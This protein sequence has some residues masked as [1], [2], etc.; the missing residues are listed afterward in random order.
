MSGAERNVELYPWYVGLYSAF[1][2]MPVFFLYFSEYLTVAGVLQLEAIYYAGVVVM[3]VPSGWTSDRLGRRTTLIIGAS[4]LLAGY[5]TLFAAGWW[6]DGAFVGFAIG[7]LFLAF[8]IAFHSGTKTSLHYESL[9]SAGRVDEYDDRE[10]MIARINRASSAGAALIGGALTIWALS[11]AYL[12]SALVAIGLIGLAISFEPPAQTD[13]LD[14][15]G[16]PS[17][18]GYTDEGFFRQVRQSLG[19][20]DDPALRWL[21][22]F[23]VAMT[24]LLHI[25]Y[26]FYQPY[27]ELLSVQL[28]DDSKWAGLAAGAHM[29]IATGLGAWAAGYSIQIR[30]RYGT[31]ATL[32]ATVTGQ[33]VLI[34]FL[35]AYLHPAIAILVLARSLPS[36]LSKA[37][38]NAAVTPRIPQ[39]HRAT[40]L[41]VQSLAGRLAFSLSLLGLSFLAS[42]RP[43]LGAPPSWPA[44]SEL[45]MVS[46]AVGIA[47][48]LA[49][50]ATGPDSLDPPAKHSG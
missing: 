10:A 23:A 35:G 33:V 2:W 25:P 11:F 1:F 42:V 44:L 5:S 15:E 22:G 17:T 39:T 45:L 47:A 31:R 41:S 7:Q 38:M 28:I 18:P 16:A 14:S 29:A 46:A 6:L 34:G 13:A 19:F 50:A 27:L 21:F 36:A 24:V 20:L 48:A 3:E 43:E 30:N 37:P 9:E 26:E 40:Y 4:C 49:L 32:L 8:G 12:A